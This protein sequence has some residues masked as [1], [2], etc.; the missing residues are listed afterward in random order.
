MAMQCS[1]GDTVIDV[2]ARNGSARRGTLSLNHGEVETPVFMP[3]GTYGTV[4][5]LTPMQLEDIGTQVLLGNT[6]HLM[7]TCF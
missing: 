2:K 1:V 6:F 5:G 7:H 4:K 3:C